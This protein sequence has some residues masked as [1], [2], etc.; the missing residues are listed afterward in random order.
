MRADLT[1]LTASVGAR[2]TKLEEAVASVADQTLPPRTHK[3]GLDLEREGAPTIL[4]RL[5]GDVE[6]EWVM[7]LDDDDVLLPNHIETV[8]EQRHRATVTYSYCENE[9][10]VFPWYNEPFS[11]VHFL[12]R[13]TVAH[14]AMTRAA[15]IRAV[16]GWRHVPG[17]DYD[18]WRRL[19][20]AGAT[21]RSIPEKTWVYRLNGNNQSWGEE[22]A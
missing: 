12:T 10:R 8:W 22:S 15:T 9:G 6:T 5:L 17:Y 2:A 19:F 16:D 1:V 14:T 20:S 11:P 7:V 21:F 13:C 3:I 18:L 4:N